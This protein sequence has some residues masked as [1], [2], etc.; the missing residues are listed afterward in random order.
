MPIAKPLRRVLR[1]LGGE[2]KL[3]MQALIV[4]TQAILCNFVWLGHSGKR[5]NLLQRIFFN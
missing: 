1:R 3:K 4:R 5:G 2:R